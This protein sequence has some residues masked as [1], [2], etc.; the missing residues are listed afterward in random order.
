MKALHSHPWYHVF[1]P[2]AC[3]L[4][5]VALVAPFAGRIECLATSSVLDGTASASLSPASSKA[6]ADLERVSQTQLKSCNAQGPTIPIDD[7]SSSA[8]QGKVVLSVAEIERQATTIEGHRVEAIAGGARITCAMQAIEGQLGPDGLRLESVGAAAGKGVFATQVR[9]LGR[10]DGQ[11]QAV[12][13][14][15]VRVVDG[16]A[17][18]DR[19]TVNEEVRTT[20]GG[21]RH[22]FVVTTPPS[23]SGEL[24][25]RVAWEGA[26]VT[27]CTDDRVSLNLDCGR[28]IYWHK[29]L[30]TDAVG[31]NLVS[32]FCFDGSGV[33][34]T[35]ADHDA[36]YP[37][38]I[39]PTY[40]DADYVSLGTGI[41]GEVLAL[42]VSGTDLYVGGGF[43]SAG[44][45]SMSNIAKWNG[46]AWSSLGSGLNG[47]VKALV[48]SGTNLYVGGSFTS[49]GGVS[50]NSIAKWNGV[51]WTALGVGMTGWVNALAVS[52]TDLYVGGYGYF[53]TASGAS[54]YAVA[55][56]NGSA[57]S[58]LKT[59]MNGADTVYAFAVSGNLLYVGGMFL[60]V[61][62]KSVNYIAA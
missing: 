6:W 16:V 39:D 43:T 58:A 30:V 26:S 54:T 38:R 35:V 52:G 49:A 11:C 37:L 27:K 7:S 59:G 31:K 62:N 19:G 51:S 48:V 47:V 42:A 13:S 55:K 41:N 4:V 28:E 25:L 21:I 32:G 40:T 20:A 33:L 60:S 45:V 1:M 14:G 36:R 8:S 18:L 12:S 61:D 29:L 22:D 57:W 5:L 46:S 10:S 50:A 2:L 3:T 44:G 17:I 56:W 53:T 24:T 34:I 15:T 9:G 23:G